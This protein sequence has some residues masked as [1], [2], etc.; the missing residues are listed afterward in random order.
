MELD[1]E[2]YLFVDERSESEKAIF[3]LRSKGISF[4]KILVTQNGMRGWMLFEFGTSKTPILAFKNNIVIGF[5]NIKDF[6]DKNFSKDLK[7]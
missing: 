2:I 1:G 3:L 4:K 7:K 5:E 6:I